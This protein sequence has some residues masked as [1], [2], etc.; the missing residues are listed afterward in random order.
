MESFM[1]Q[2]RAGKVTATEID[3]FIDQ[4][5]YGTS[6]DSLPDFLGMTKAEYEAWLRDPAILANL[7]NLTPYV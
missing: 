7:L 1:Q 3:D 2:Y 4:W 5:H 6:A